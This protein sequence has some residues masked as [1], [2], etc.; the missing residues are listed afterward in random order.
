[1]LNTS[2]N[3]RGEPIVETPDDAIRCFLNC[4]LDVLY[5]EGRRITKATLASSDDPYSLIPNLN[6]GLGV[7]AHADLTSGAWESTQHYIITRTRYRV[8]ITDAEA[9]IL[10]L[11][12]GKRTV[13]ML[14]SRSDV[15]AGQVIQVLV[16][17]QTKG[18][19][20]FAWPSTVRDSSA[21]ARCAG[22]DSDE[23]P[24][25]CSAVTIQGSDNA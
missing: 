25:H 6:A 22:T 11:I 10:R 18:L 19:L 17:L 24:G 9:A 4:N 13:R 3:V 20:S 23:Q 14:A 16:A 21:T 1:V 15:A 12:N 5:L 7:E 8:P 2:F